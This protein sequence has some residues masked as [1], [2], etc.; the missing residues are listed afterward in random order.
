MS[1]FSYIKTR[2]RDLE[3]LQAALTDLEIEWK[4]GPRQ[5]KGYQGQTCTANVV[6]EQPN[7]HD[8]GFAWNGEEYALVA[9]LQFWKQPLSVEG[10]LSQVVQRYAYQKIVNETARQGFEVTAQQ[11]QKDGSIRVVVQRWSS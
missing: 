5:V 9:D 2:I 1:H 4:P 6:I 7:G 11:Q 10:F 8:I 3:E